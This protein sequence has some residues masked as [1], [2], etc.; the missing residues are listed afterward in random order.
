M[1][2]RAVPEQTPEQERWAEVYERFDP[3]QPAD[4][5][6]WRVERKYSPANAI[7]RELNR[8]MG[9]HKRFMILGG[10]GSGKSTELLAIAA[11]RSKQGPVVF[12]DLV[13]HFE[14]RVGDAAAL[15]RIQPWEVVL[16]V[17]LGIYKAA[18]AHFGHSWERR[19]TKSLEKAAKAFIDE[20][21]SP[22]FDLAKL[23]STVAVLAGG[24]I[25]GVVAGPAGAF[26]GASLAAVGETGKSIQWRFPLGIPGRALRSDQDQRVQQLLGAVNGLIG[27]LQSEYETKLSV[28]I[29]GLDRIKD[30]ART[31]ALFVES[32][33]LGS[34][35]CDVVST[36]PIALHW[37]SLRKHVRKFTT[38]TL[39]NAP[40]IDRTTPESWEPG[41]PGID[42]CIEVFRR[43][44]ADLDPG[45]ALIPEPAL[46]KLAY[47]SGGRIREFVRLIRELSGPA[48]DDSLSSATDAIVDQ[49]IDSLRAETEAG[50]TR[51]HIGI[52]RALIEE[53]GELP[54]DELVSEMLDVCLILPYPNE[55]EWFFPHP[56]LLK[57]K[58]ADAIAG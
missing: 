4:N 50:L 38:K 25:G 26:A 21:D 36:G 57:V 13:N 11:Q 53:P 23:A 51:G 10:I 32:S 17:G 37:G 15:D 3:L 47:Y 30:R 33:L 14:K 52:L 5:P 9:G 1:Y 19:E 28:F 42:L 27:T 12:I 48:W 45:G 44:T 55:S 8:P 24:A 31:K 41:G 58:L 40:V 20:E 43:R 29:D 7:V 34:L 39:A 56:L 16:L 46:R 49:A 18:Q 35:E 54:D 6:G 2:T 22:T